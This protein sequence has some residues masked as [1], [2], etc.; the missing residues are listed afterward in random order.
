[1]CVGLCAYMNVLCVSVFLIKA[2]ERNTE[3]EDRERQRDNDR[4][5]REINR[6]KDREREKN[7]VSELI[8][9]AYIYLQYINSIS[10][11]QW[12]STEKLYT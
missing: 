12:S 7:L 11:Q 1:M 2:G 10:F 5:R 9:N 6:E 8:R 3:R 4:E